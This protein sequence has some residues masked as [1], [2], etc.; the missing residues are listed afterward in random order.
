LI[1][2]AVVYLFA[3]VT[4]IECSRDFIAE[5]LRQRFGL[6]SATIIRTGI[7]Y[8][9]KERISPGELLRAELDSWSK[10]EIENSSLNTYRLRLVALNGCVFLTRSY[11]SGY[12]DA[13]NKVYQINYFINT[14]T[15]RSVTIT[16]DDRLIGYSLGTICWLLG[17][18]LIILSKTP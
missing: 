3:R 9:Q 14:L 18:I 15:E 10:Q 11:F 8:R 2:A 16:Q 17:A 12:A 7:Q 1:G 4:T 5:R 6:I 13:S